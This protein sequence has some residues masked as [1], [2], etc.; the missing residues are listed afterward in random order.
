MRS[1]SSATSTLKVSCPGARQGCV[2]CAPSAKPRITR[3]LRTS[4][5]E[6]RPAKEMPTVEAPSTSRTEPTRA[7]LS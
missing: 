3:R 4:S 5:M 6:M 2:G 7:S 1:A